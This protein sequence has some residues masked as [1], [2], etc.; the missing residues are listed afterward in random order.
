VTDVDPYP[1][2][3]GG[4]AFAFLLAVLFLAVIGASVGLVL[5]RREVARQHSDE[6]NRRNQQSQEYPQASVAAT[7][8]PKMT[9]TP[10]MTGTH[11]PRYSEDRARVELIQV[12]YINTADS[13]A[14]ICQDGKGS[15]WY[16]GHRKSDGG[17][18]LLPGV[19]PD[20]AGGYVATNT[21]GDGT[22]KYRVSRRS[23]IVERPYSAPEEQPVL[24]AEPG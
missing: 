19:Q 4:R 2:R 3:R 15:L 7:P 9:G 16:Q 21:D 6:V 20:G 22:T 11:C 23:L 5:G 10:R 24:S 8:T 12:L 13:E 18:I 14:W 17:M 1:R